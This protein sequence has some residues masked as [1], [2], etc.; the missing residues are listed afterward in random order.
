MSNGLRAVSLFSGAGGLDV[1]FERAGYQTIWAN[2]FDH[3]AAEAWRANRPDNAVAMVEGDINEHLSEL[4]ALRGKVDVLF[5][6]PP[7]QGFSVAG[8]MDPNDQRSTLVWS[9]ME[10]VDRVRPHVFLIENVAALARLEKWRS[11]RDGIVARAD[12]LGYD[13]TWRVH[14]ASD[15]GVPERRERV[16]FVGVEKGGVPAEEIYEA[17]RAYEKQPRTVRDVLTSVGAYGTDENPQ[18]CSS[19]VSLA[20]SPVMRKSPYAGMLVNGA[21]RPMNLDGCAPTLPASM[22]GNKTPIIDQTALEDPARENWFV[23]YHRRLLDGEADPATETVPDA[24]RRLTIAEAAAIQTF[25]RDYVFAGRKTKQYRQIGNAVPC[26]LAEA[27]ASAIYDCFFSS[28]SIR[29]FSSS[30][31]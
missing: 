21:G 11:V 31:C 9:F 1:G 19:H 5:G 8:K 22:G 17:L 4:D 23:S 7:C 24:A 16:M 3:D 27:M 10:A 20:K 2:E 25:P 28:P 26:G 6:G 12:E 15:Y 29:A 30:S 13:C 14:L 18:T